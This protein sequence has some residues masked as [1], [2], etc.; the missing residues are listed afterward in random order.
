M[1]TGKTSP[2]TATHYSI[3]G[4]LILIVGLAGISAL[5]LFLNQD[6]VIANGAQVHIAWIIWGS[7]FSALLL[8]VAVSPFWL[9]HK[10]KKEQRIYHPDN[11]HANQVNVITNTRKTTHP[12]FFALRQYLHNLHGRFWQH[13]IRILLVTGTVADV[14]QLAPGL[15]HE[16]W[17]EDGGT[18]LLWGGDPAEPADNAWLAALGKLRYRPADG[19]VWVTSAFDQLATINPAPPHPLP[20]GSDM[21]ALVHA[22]RERL[23]VSGWQLPVYAWSLH[24]RAGKP[25]GRTV[26]ATGCLLPAG[27][28]A[29]TLAQALAA[30][31]PE[32]V[33]RGVQQVCCRMPHPFL[34]AL[35][36][37]LTRQPASITGPLSAMTGPYRPFPLAGVVFSQPFSTTQPSGQHHW[38]MDKS[39]EVLP[40]HVRVLPPL[41]RPRKSGIP[42]QKVLSPMAFVLLLASVAWICAAYASNHSH[43]TGARERVVAGAQQ[44][45]PLAARLQALA[46]LQKTLARL[47]YRAAQGAPWYTRAGLSQN[48]ALLAALMPHY[49]AGAHALLR[50]AA[51]EHLRSQLQAFTALPPGSPMREQQAEATWD[52]LKLY[53]MLARPQHMDADW[54]ARTL[55]Q[56]WPV[57]DGVKDGAWQGLAPSLLSFYGA[58]LATHP[59][60]ALPED[61]QLVR[62]VRALL[63]RLMGQ[64]NSE[65]TLYQNMLAQVA[66]L[67][68]DMHLED[69]T[70]NTDVSRLFT[71]GETVPGVFTRQAWEQAVQPAIESVVSARRDELDWV[72]TD[73]QQSVPLQDAITPE[74]LKQQLTDRYFA[75]FSGAWLAFL[76]SLRLHRAATL[77]DAIDQLTLMAD[78]RQSPL[79]ALMNT[80]NVQGRTG[81]AREAISDSLVKSARNLL[82][83]GSQGVIDQSTGVTGP[84]DNTFGPL[85]ALTDT[86]RTGQQEHSLQAY[87]TR[88]TQVR[89]RLQQVTHAADPQAMAQSLAQTVFQG[90]TVDL[91]QTRDYG[92][93]LAAGLG[94]EWR[95]LGETLFVSPMEQAWQQVLAPAAGSLN[96]QWQQAVV[97]EWNR[98]FGGRYPFNN[99]GSD[100]SLPLLAKYLN[101]DSG[102]IT[103]FLQ[104]R[105]Q[106][107]LNREGSQWVPDSTHSQG[108]VF[109][110]E[111]IRAINTLSHI[112]D[113]AFTE[114]AAGMHFELRPGTAGGVMQT[115][116]VIDNQALIYMNQMPAWKRFAWPADTEAAGA[117]LSWMSTTAGTRLYADIPGAWGW[118]RLL[119]KA[120]V[121]AYPGVGSSYS[122]SWQAQDGRALNYTLRT[123]AGE[124]PL[125]LLKLR[126]FRL[127]ETLFITEGA[128]SSPSIHDSGSTMIVD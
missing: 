33:S 66:H 101:A 13:K 25:A 71:T 34:L 112:A 79:V 83:S 124:G 29:D 63:I 94:Q 5:L 104:T 90:K 32:L 115:D 118:I 122:L 86:P 109:N 78:V 3:T 64:R 1:T 16:F 120:T 68:A 123:E 52:Q 103:Q 82:G 21:N 98:A 81:Q 4:Y 50:D 85:L 49:Q 37:Q 125:V 73:S 57:R 110:P 23:A 36:D 70:G 61:K 76:N 48:E 113:V 60:G 8:V 10:F 126:G 59:E 128:S 88:V 108:L 77:S 97:S 54:F 107:V 26:Q 2:G 46:E 17:L 53:L 114:G 93:L 42:W 12:A 35:A 87:L 27:C 74:A 119:D 44:N 65:A 30:M 121:S 117:R 116:M 75:D 14:E 11:T 111:F 95:G 22:L 40:A 100:V 6:R 39:W 15:T 19:L 84:L 91:T 127:P 47:Q 80:L 20:S 51:A 62:Q 106:G 55:L 31:V 43:I 56:G 96:A 18:L 89:L 41:L 72:L 9:K 28:D 105:L 58:Q 69:M 67:Y 45:Q 99:T 102:R 24:P 38:V 92:S 7:V